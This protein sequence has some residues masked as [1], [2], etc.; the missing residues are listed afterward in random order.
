MSILKDLSTYKPSFTKTPTA[1]NEE[2]IQYTCILF[3]HE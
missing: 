2:H 1:S 3:A